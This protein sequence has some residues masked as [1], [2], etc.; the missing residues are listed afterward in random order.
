[1]LETLTVRVTGGATI[2]DARTRCKKWQATSTAQCFRS[3]KVTRAGLV[4]GGGPGE[5]VMQE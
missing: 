4:G 1:M 5:A 2:G 3:L